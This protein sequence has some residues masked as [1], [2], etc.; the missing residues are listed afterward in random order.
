VFEKLEKGEKNPCLDLGSLE[1]AAIRF[2]LER[3]QRFTRQSGIFSLQFSCT[4]LYPGTLESNSSSL[5]EPSGHQLFLF[6][7]NVNNHNDAS[8]TCDY[9]DKN[10]GRHGKEKYKDK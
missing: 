5:E 1:P 6:C 4:Y 2:T 10:P 8:D 7:F 3:L 9:K